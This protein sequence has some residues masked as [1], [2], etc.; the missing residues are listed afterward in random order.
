MLK[1]VKNGQYYDNVVEELKERCSERG[2]EFPF[3]VAQIRQKLK[4][5]ISSGIKCFYEDKELGNWFGKLL[6]IIS[7]MDNC[8]PQQAIAPGRKV[9]ETIGKEANPEESHDDDVCEEEASPGSSSRSSDGASNGI[10]KPVPTP[11]NRKKSR[12]KTE[13]FLTEMGKDN[14]YT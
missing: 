11:A 3:N 9:L 12:E 2:E 6:P 5:C 13:S 7:L 1:N 8:Q 4:L 14:E 10:R